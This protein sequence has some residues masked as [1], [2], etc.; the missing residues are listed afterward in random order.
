MGEDFNCTGNGWDIL[1][2][3]Q[4]PPKWFLI[5]SILLFLSLCLNIFFCVSKCSSGDCRCQPRKKQKRGQRRMEE[6]PIYGNL[7][8]TDT[9]TA[10]YT[11]GDPL[12][13]VS[14]DMQSK[15]QDC[16]ANLTLKPP[17]L[18]SGRSSPQIQFSDMVVFEEPLESEKR[19]EPCTGSSSPLSDLYA[20]VQT[21]RTKTIH[22]ADSM[23]EYANHL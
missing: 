14:C 5:I 11:G 12:Q 17:R 16:Y 8:Y 3:L 23:E 13:G 10:T 4:E 19:D 15:S 9:G 7:G 1:H 22:T 20:S 6:N 21:Q 18:Q 2:F